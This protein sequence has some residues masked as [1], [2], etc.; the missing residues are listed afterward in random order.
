VERSRRSYFLL[1]GLA[2]AVGWSTG[3]WAVPLLAFGVLE[4]VWTAAERAGSLLAPMPG[5]VVR[6]PAHST[7]PIVVV[8]GLSFPLKLRS[9]VGLV[10]LF[11]V[12]ILEEPR[13]QTAST[14]AAVLSTASARSCTCSTAA[15]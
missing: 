12:E 13:L 14:A 7:A 11:A 5:A 6:V 15:G 10:P 4:V 8:D 2:S 9:M 3:L 1:L